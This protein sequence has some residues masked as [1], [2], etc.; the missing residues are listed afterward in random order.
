MKESE[1]LGIYLGLPLS[2]KRPSKREVQSVVN[3]VRGKLAMWKSKFLSCIGKLT[4]IKASMNIYHCFLLYESHVVT[5]RHPKGTRS[6][7]Q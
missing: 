2:H 6:D 4:L 7:L 3:K 5:K 1:N